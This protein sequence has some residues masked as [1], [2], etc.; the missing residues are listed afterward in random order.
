M[1]K[2]VIS[3]FAVLILLSGCSSK[4]SLDLVSSTVD[5]RSGEGMLEEMGI[6]SE[7]K[8]EIIVP[9]TLSYN[10]VLKN[11]GEKTL[12]G[13]EKLN[14]TFEYN[15]GIRIYIEPNEKLKEVSEEI[16]GVNIFSFDG[17]GRQIAKLGTV[18]TSVPIKPNQEGVYTLHFNLGSLEGNPE[19]RIAPSSEQ[20]EKLKEHAMDA[21][22]IVFVE[23]EEIASF[24]L[25]N[26]D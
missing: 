26:L 2:S 7:L 1:L 21:T 11:T 12:G 17:E 5:F 10:F 8:E 19:I 24:D 20:L 18:E 6:T 25:S 4:P 16:I 3:I 14:E 15:D 13:A 23:G 9:N 22:L